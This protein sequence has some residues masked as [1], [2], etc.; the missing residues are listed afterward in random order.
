MDRPRLKMLASAVTLLESG[1]SSDAISLLQIS[2]WYFV[3]QFIIT[4]F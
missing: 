1:K 4:S 3:G 2:A